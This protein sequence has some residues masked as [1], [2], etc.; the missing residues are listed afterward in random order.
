MDLDPFDGV[1]PEITWFSYGAGFGSY[2]SVY[3]D[4]GVESVALGTITT[5]AGTATVDVGTP[6]YMSPLGLSL[7]ASGAYTLP[8]GQS[9][10]SFSAE[11]AGGGGFYSAYAFGLSANTAVSFAGLANVQASTT[12][13]TSSAN[14]TEESRASVLMTA[15]SENPELAPAEDLL[16]IELSSGYYDPSLQRWVF[17][18][19]PRSESYGHFMG[20]TFAN[21]TS[22]WVDG[23]LSMRVMAEGF[24]TVS[25]VPEPSTYA[26]MFAGLA[27]VGGA[28]A[29][30]RARGALAA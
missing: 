9:W 16:G 14:Q 17:A 4:I 22:E 8:Y 10:G 3:G 24:A 20:V 23:H 12:Q 30:K 28:A 18:A 27:V 26:L 13:G 19:A 29:R 15:W 25:P 21:S 1:T 11:I 5:S 6:Y 7:T 2:A